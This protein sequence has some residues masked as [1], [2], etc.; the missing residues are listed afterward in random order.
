[1][2]A[3][4][5]GGLSRPEQVQQEK[6]EMHLT[7]H[8]WTPGLIAGR[9]RTKITVEEKDE[10]DLGTERRSGLRRPERSLKRVPKRP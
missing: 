4:E 2:P 8:R 6:L 9:G 1:M 7:G 10:V 5:R 3:F